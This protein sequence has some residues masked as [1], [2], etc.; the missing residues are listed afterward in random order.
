MAPPTTIHLPTMKPMMRLNPIR[1][2]RPARMSV[3]DR[4]TPVVRIQ[5][6]DTTAAAGDLTSPASRERIVMG[7]DQRNKKHQFV[8]KDHDRAIKRA[9]R[10]RKKRRRHA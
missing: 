1:R 3:V 4:I 9:F 6:G 7:K 10:Q 2:T 8:K 5:V